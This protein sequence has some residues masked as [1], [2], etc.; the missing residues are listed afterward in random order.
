MVT[1]A[2]VGYDFGWSRFEG[3]LC[4]P[5]DTDPSCSETGLTFPVVEYGRSVGRTVVGG[6]VYHG[7]TARSLSS[8]YLYADA[9]SGTIRG[10][11]QVNGV[12]V[13]QI[14]LTPQLQLEGIVSFAEDGDGELLVANLFEGAIYRLTGG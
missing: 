7:P 13:E 11:R 8:Y 6:I 2:P 12:P 5:N 14:D 4:N 3:S 9:N 1:V 10:F